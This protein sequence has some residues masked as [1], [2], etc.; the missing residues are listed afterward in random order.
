MVNKTQILG[1]LEK[2]SSKIRSFGVYKLFLFGS[3]STNDQKKMSDIDFIVEFKKG[4][5][6][7]DD[8]MNLL[9]FLEDMF[10]KKIDLVEKHLI[11]E[12]LKP[13]ILG[14]NKVEAK[15]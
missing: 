3:Y 13:Q 15:I 8:Y 6:L 2:N 1:K 12:E 7:F 14:G 11:R 9:H 10:N 4:R 5:G